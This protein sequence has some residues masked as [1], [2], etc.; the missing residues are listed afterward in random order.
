[1]AKGESW[2]GNQR[3]IEARYCREQHTTQS[4]AAKAP[5]YKDPAYTE[6]HRPSDPWQDGFGVPR[7]QMW[8][9]SAEINT[10]SLMLKDKGNEE[11]Y[12]A[13]R[14]VKDRVVKLI[15]TTNIK[16]R[17]GKGQR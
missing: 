11:A 9:L 1:M 2:G 17:H 16:E 5:G 4:E 8:V 6:H 7:A 14:K 10:L 12:R 3:S 15:Q 13:L